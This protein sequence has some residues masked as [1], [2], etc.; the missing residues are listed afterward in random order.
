MPAAPHDTPMKKARAFPHATQEKY[1]FVWAC[2]GTPETSLPVFKEWDDDSFKKV[3]C[4]P[5]EFNAN[6]FRASRIFSMPRTFRSYTTG[7]TGI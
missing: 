1:G 3:V 5:W 7:R 6:P 4:G 2:L